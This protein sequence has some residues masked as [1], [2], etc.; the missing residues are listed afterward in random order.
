MPF[1]LN[2]ELKTCTFFF[3]LIILSNNLIA[4]DL[5]D[6]KNSTLYA[7]YLQTSKQYKLAAEEYD[8]IYFFNN[9]N[10]SILTRLL[11]NTRKYGNSKSV[12]EIVNKTFKKSDSLSTPIFTEYIK[13]LINIQPNLV[14]EIIEKNK[15]VSIQQKAILQS[16]YNVS[17]YDW[18]N[19][20]DNINKSEQSSMAITNTKEVLNSALKTKYKSPILAATFSTI[21]PGLGKIYT[22]NIKDGFIALIFVGVNTFQSYR[23]FNKKGINSAGGWIFGSLATG[24]YVGNIYGAFKAAKIKNKKTKDAY[25]KQIQEFIDMD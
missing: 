20:L 2:S 24:F 10:D 1:K 5:F 8:R 23:Y 16:F 6:V 9:S 14:N 12:V 3:A 7:N 22:G 13:S 21:V 19:A 18:K 15:V 17:V 11:Y 25:K 4:Q